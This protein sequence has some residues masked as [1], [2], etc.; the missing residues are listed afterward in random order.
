MPKS[1]LGSP[2]NSAQKYAFLFYVTNFPSTWLGVPCASRCGLWQAA[3]AS[4]S[5]AMT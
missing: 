5:N 3:R 4:K 1:R 2:F